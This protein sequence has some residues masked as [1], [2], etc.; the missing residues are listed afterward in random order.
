MSAFLRVGLRAAVRSASLVVIAVTFAFVIERFLPRV[1]R[2]PR[3]WLDQ[4]L[5]WFVAPWDPRVHAAIFRALPWTIAVVGVGTLVAI[6][7]GTLLGAWLARPGRSGRARAAWAPVLLAACTPAWIIG[8]L[9]VALFGVALRWLPTGNAIS[10]LQRWADQVDIL[11]DLAAHAILPIGSLALAGIGLFAVSMRALVTTDA[12]TDYALYG[13][14][15]GLRMRSRF[16]R[17]EVRPALGPQ[18][19]AAALALG[20]IVT[21]AFFV[22]AVFSYPGLGWL[23]VHAMLAYDFATVRGVMLLLVFGV[24]VV[25]LVIDLALPLVDPRVRRG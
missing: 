10:P 11:L 22:E 7:V 25:T 18:L 21:G 17:W 4:Y 16:L 24:A 5:G 9:L 2:D 14:S 1:Q 15:L 13:E 19:T 20:S 3:P 23:F 6:V 8:L 12:G